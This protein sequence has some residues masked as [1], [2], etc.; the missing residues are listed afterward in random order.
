MEGCIMFEVG[1]KLPAEII[2]PLDSLI[3]TDFSA[4]DQFD[5]TS[6]SFV[7]AIDEL[8]TQLTAAQ[9]AV[10]V[11]HNLGDTGIA[12]ALT[13]HGLA[14]AAQADATTALGRDEVTA[15]TG[16]IDSVEAASP[17]TAQFNALLAA[18][19]TAGVFT[20]PAA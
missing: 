5:T 7:G 9:A 19:R 18:L 17:T 15:V 12:D 14:D 2:L 4:V 10:I 8:H 20:G 6:N 11:A 1:A 13:A 3:T 16:P